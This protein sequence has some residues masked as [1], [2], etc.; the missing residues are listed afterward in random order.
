[1]NIVVLPILFEGE[2]KAVDGA[3][4]ARALQLDPPGVSRPIDGE[5]RHRA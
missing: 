5:H 2:V 4:I 3:F 1:M